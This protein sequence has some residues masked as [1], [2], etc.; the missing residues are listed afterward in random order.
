MAKSSSFGVLWKFLRAYFVFAGAHAFYKLV[1]TFLNGFKAKRMLKNIE[2][3]KGHWLLGLA[4]ELGKNFNR[5]HDWRNDLMEDNKTIKLPEGGLLGRGTIITK[6]PKLVKHILKDSFDCWTKADLSSDWFNVYFREWLGFGIFGIR[7]TRDKE[8]EKKLWVL[9]RKIASKIFTT[10]NFKSFMRE[11]F[12][13]KAKILVEVIKKESAGGN[14][15]DMQQKFFAYTMDSIMF[16][17]FGRNAE[18]MR[19]KSDAYA[20]AFD[21]A[22]RCLMKY[23]ITNVPKLLLISLLPY[24]FGGLQ[25]TGGIVGELLIRNSPVGQRFRKANEI[26]TR[27]SNIIIDQRRENPDGRD[28]LALFMK[29]K[30]ENGVK[31]SDKRYQSILRDIVLSFVIAGR[32]TT[33]CTLSWAFYILATNPEIQERL[34][35]EIDRECKNDPEFEDLSAERMPYLNGVIYETLRLYPPVPFDPKYCS[36][37]DGDV[38]PDGTKVPHGTQLAYFPYAMGRDKDRWAE[39]LKVIP[40]RWIPF[41][42]PDLFEFPVFQ[43]GPR[44]CLGMNMAVFE[45]KLLMSVL[46]KEYSFGLKDGEA[47]KISYSIMLTMSIRNGPDSHSLWMIPR[48]RRGQ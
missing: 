5:I 40:D 34:L 19:G 25:A 33:A 8:S 15:V 37:K 36:K 10:N 44:Q 23:V 13:K 6:D 4:M 14:P 30:D 39:P 35:E 7:H 17:F 24:P 27:E 42:Q 29:H 16:L 9:Q 46:L 21:E 47:S 1:K 18:T 45:A 48:E 11:T 43:A 41:K 32:D 22:H 3:P 38:L 28:L 26:L 20:E 12:L 31:L 2:G